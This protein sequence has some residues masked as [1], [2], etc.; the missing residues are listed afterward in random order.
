M[1]EVVDIVVV[2]VWSGGGLIGEDEGFNGIIVC[3][4]VGEGIV[5]LVVV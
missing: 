3:F 4:E 2:D 1:G 5:K